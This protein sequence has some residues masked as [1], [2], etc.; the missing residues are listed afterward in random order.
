[1]PC[2]FP[3]LWP[4]EVP[5]SPAAVRWRGRLA[6]REAGR[7][8]ATL[9]AGREAEAG[10]AALGDPQDAAASVWTVQHSGWKQQP[11]EP[12]GDGGGATGGGGGEREEAAGGEGGERRAPWWTG[13]RPY[14]VISCQETEMILKPAVCVCVCVCVCEH[15]CLCKCVNPCTWINLRSELLSPMWP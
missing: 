11:A 7:I 14:G 4:Q 15:L 3:L 10:D 6:L 2:G 13:T 1:M 9:A 5:H 12:C 8:H